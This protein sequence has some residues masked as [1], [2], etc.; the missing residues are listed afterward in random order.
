MWHWGLVL[1]V[2]VLG[3]AF[4]TYVCHLMAKESAEQRREFLVVAEQRHALLDIVKR[5]QN[6]RDQCREELLRVRWE[7][8]QK[9]K[10]Q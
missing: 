4:P 7:Y 6:E 9:D 8:G 2:I 1:A 10:R 5:R 3:P